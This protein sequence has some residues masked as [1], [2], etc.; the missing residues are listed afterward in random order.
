[1]KVQATLEKEWDLSFIKDILRQEGRKKAS[2][3]SSRGRSNGSKRGKKK[4]NWLDH[5]LKRK[6]VLRREGG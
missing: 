3:C 2:C 5:P 1:V 6:I 4:K